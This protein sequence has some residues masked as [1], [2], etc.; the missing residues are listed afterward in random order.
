MD[1]FK[2]LDWETAKKYATERFMII[3]TLNEKSFT[4][5]PATITQI[6]ITQKDQNENIPKHLF[7]S[8]ILHQSQTAHRFFIRKISK[9]LYTMLRD[10]EDD[11]YVASDVGIKMLK[12][13]DSSEV[14]FSS[15]LKTAYR[16]INRELF[17]PFLHSRI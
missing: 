9:Y 15:S 5:T 1:Y 12:Q 14:I 16:K 17:K 4:S 11:V 7:V 3:F 13:D 6:N 10:Q 2:S 8:I